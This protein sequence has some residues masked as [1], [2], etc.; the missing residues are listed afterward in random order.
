MTIVTAIVSPIARPRPRMTA[1]AIP[2]AP[3][4]NT[5]MVVSHF[6]AP[7]ASAASRCVLGTAASTSRT[8]A[9]II[10][11]IMIAKITPPVSSPIPVIGP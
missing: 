11:V 10:G 9:E 6:V 7:S 4:T 8:T 1:P 5:T 3:F 2:G